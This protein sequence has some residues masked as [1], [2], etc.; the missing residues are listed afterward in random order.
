MFKSPLA[1]MGGPRFRGHSFFCLRVQVLQA[2]EHGVKQSGEF[3]RENEGL[4]G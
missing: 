1:A 3:L 2:F 4:N